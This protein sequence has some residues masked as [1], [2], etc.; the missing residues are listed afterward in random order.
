MKQAIKES[1]HLN[2]DK[3][4]AAAVRKVAAWASLIVLVGGITNW[5]ISGATWKAD[6]RHGISANKEAICDVRDDVDGMK[7]D[8]NNIKINVGILLERTMP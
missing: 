1:F 2:G 4:A 5:V 8:L 3:A 7:D 6:H